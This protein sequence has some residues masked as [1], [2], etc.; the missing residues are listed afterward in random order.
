MNTEEL[1][2]KLDESNRRVLELKSKLK[3]INEIH[4]AEMDSLEKA[5]QQIRLFVEAQD[6]D[7]KAYGRLIDSKQSV[8][9]QW[10]KSKTHC[11]RLEEQI[12]GLTNLTGGPLYL[13]EFNQLMSIVDM[14]W[15]ERLLA[16]FV[17]FTGK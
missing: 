5:Q 3:G 10:E 15:Y 6:E 16:V 11:Q 2:A 13:Y 12:D 7:R 14:P 1:H 8:E 9:S 4:A 17:G